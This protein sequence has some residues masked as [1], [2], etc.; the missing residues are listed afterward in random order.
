[1]I[2]RSIVDAVSAMNNNIIREQSFQYNG[3]FVLGDKVPRSLIYLRISQR[4][5]FKVM[6]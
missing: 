5:F 1:M 2:V 6:T 4:L 3:F